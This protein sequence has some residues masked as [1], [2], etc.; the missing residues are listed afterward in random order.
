MRQ[1]PTGTVTFFFSDI[2][3]STRLV[4]GLGSR[5]REV[6]GDH[7]SIIR[8]VIARAD[9]TEIRTE[10]DSFFVVFE[11]AVDAVV[12]ACDIQLRMAD[13][14]W[15]EAGAVRVRIGLHTGE[16]VLGG[17]DYVGIDVHRA[18]RIGA[19]GHGGQVVVSETTRT[20]AEA[21]G[22]DAEFVDLGR[23]RLKDIH[24]PIR[25]HQINVPGLPTAYPPLRTIDAHPNN[26]LAAPTPLVGRDED[27]A[28]I[29]TDLT[30]NRIVTL[31]GPG[32]VGKT[33]LALQAAS[34]ALGSHPD[35]V[36]FVDLSPLTE[37]GLVAAS[38]AA[39]LSLREGSVSVLVDYL[40]GKEVLLTLDNFEQVV[41]AAGDVSGILEGAPGTQFLVTSQVPL[42]I[43]G[44]QVRR[45]P[46]LSLPA[47][48]TAAGEAASVK[49][50]AARARAADPS[51]RINDDPEAVADL[52]RALGGLPLALELAAARV[53][54]LTPREIADRLGAGHDVG[55]GRSDAPDRH[56]SLTDAIAWSVGLLS[57]ADRAALQR[58]SVFH[59][60]ASLDA[61]DAVLAGAP[62][63]DPV[64]SL[65]ELVDRSLVVRDRSGPSSTRLVLLD[66]VR[67]YAFAGLEA[68]GEAGA[69][70]QRHIDFFCDLAASA[71]PEML[72]D[73]VA[74][75]LSRLEEELDNLRVV[76][77]RLIEAGDAQRGL[78]LLGSL[79]RFHQGRGHFEE[80]REWLDRFL[81]LPSAEARTAER[82][83]GLMALG[84]LEYWRADTGS[85][86]GHYKEAV[87]IAGEVG[88]G[89]LVAEARF[90][91]A[92]SLVI[93]R[94]SEEAKAHLEETLVIYEELGDLGGVA[95]VVAGEAFALLAVSDLSAAKPLLERATRLY[96]EAGRRVNATQGTIA[97]S[98]VAVYEERFDAA[99]ELA[100]EAL[101]LA[102]ELGDLF[103]TVWA[104]EWLA[105]TDVE[106]GSVDAGAAL[107]GATESARSWLGGGW[108]PIVLGLEDPGTRA[109]SRMGPAAAEAATELGRA[110]EI[111]DAVRLAR[112]EVP[113][114]D[115]LR[116][117]DQPAVM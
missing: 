59:G 84:A 86:I 1:L 43:A 98:A 97:L 51:F 101:T 7:S 95:D 26:L 82:A 64:A 6:L 24:D 96:H 37:P 78:N 90:G 115:L 58:L 71:E 81:A 41:A 70:S 113:L 10:G 22:A 114:E 111:A 17:D 112:R 99:R 40:D 4:Q 23:C 54:L 2:E 109:V 25:L 88:G 12:A 55:A 92:A 93:A 11:S 117:R 3:G 49:L 79:W 67:R 50:F 66:P 34:E 94:R 52:V 89:T 104:L 30:E 13:H 69:V 14:A 31:V 80:L 73:R 60:G 29:A 116:Q 15:P 5:Y 9:A 83:K 27:L 57:D 106:A 61:A 18:A 46:P 20:L 38:V 45:V 32:G 53:A 33:R 36:F 75:W 76:L 47:R 62:V 77:G 68:S 110:I 19:T 35:G 100:L 107:A 21:A 8:S 56:R 108:T 42:R 102:E 48:G 65:G 72:G 105:V 87:E 85:A 91:L 44:E 74:W 28:A 103:L 16:A 39:A 63:N